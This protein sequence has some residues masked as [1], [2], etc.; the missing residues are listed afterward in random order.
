MSQ[1]TELLGSIR[2]NLPIHSVRRLELRVLSGRLPGNCVEF[3]AALGGF[4]CLSW[5]ILAIYPLHVHL[6]SSLLQM[7]CHWEGV[8]CFLFPHGSQIGFLW[9][10][11]RRDP[12]AVSVALIS[13]PVAG[14]EESASGLTRCKGAMLTP[15]SSTPVYTKGGCTWV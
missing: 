1:H 11:T 12:K 3:V 5:S 10:S 2:P 7:L 13:G 4:S 14:C 9:L 15:D 8:V 6:S